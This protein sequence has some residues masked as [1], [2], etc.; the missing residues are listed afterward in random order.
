M[1]R[2]TRSLLLKATSTILLL[3]VAIGNAQANSPT[4]VPINVVAAQ[5]THTL[6]L[7]NAEAAAASLPKLSKV[8]FDFNTTGTRGAGFSFNIL[9]FKLGVNRESTATNEVTFTYTVPVPGGPL[10]PHSQP[11]THD[12]SQT[13]LTTLRAAA[14]QAKTTQT[15]GAA[16]FTNLTVILSY[17]A[18]WDATA[19]AGGA[20]SL[21][22]LDGSVDHKRADVQ[23]LTLVFGQ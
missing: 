9:I 1:N 17:A 23:T 5:V 7:F 11:V 18:E 2:T 8:V 12:F 14:Q 19:G 4:E 6:D 16:R 15:V 10:Q 21:V 22:T 13:L 3:A 20:V